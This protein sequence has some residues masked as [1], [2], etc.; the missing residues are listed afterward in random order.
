MKEPLFATLLNIALIILKLCNVIN[1]SWL[2]LILVEII[3]FNVNV[4]IKGLI[5][6][7][8]EKF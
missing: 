3:I 5:I 1:I 6:R 2:Q 7:I 8:L 4:F